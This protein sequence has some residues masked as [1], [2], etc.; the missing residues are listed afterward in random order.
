[1]SASL[2]NTS[3]KVVMIMQIGWVVD[4]DVDARID[5]TRSEGP[6]THKCTLSRASPV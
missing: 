2:P 4:V 3:K 6:K 1:M 5:G